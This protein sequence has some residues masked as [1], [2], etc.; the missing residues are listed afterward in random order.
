MG[1]IPISYNRDI[2]KQILE[3]LEK[4]EKVTKFLD[5]FGGEYVKIAFNLGLN[6]NDIGTLVPSPYVMLKGA[7]FTVPRHSQYS[8]FIELSK[9]VSSEEVKINIDQ[10]YGFTLDDVKSAYNKLKLGHTKGK[11]VIEINKE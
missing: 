7:N 5:C 11:L 10:V 3:C 2:E 1:A 6:G 9:L 4:D 8:D